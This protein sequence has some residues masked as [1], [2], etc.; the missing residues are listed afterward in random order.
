M[1]LLASWMPN[2]L[3]LHNGDHLLSTQLRLTPLIRLLMLGLPHLKR[4]SSGRRG[5]HVLR[6]FDRGDN[7]RRSVGVLL[8]LGGSGVELLE[9][10]SR[11]DVDDLLLADFDVVLHQDVLLLRRFVVISFGEQRRM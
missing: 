2:N 7:A 5:Q 3:L 11:S 10:V 6:V 8:G 9:R 1:L 4:V